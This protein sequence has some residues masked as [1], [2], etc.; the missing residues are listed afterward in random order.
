MEYVSRTE[1][2][3][4]MAQARESLKGFWGLAVGVVVVYYGIFFAIGFVPILGNI[5]SLILTGPF[6][7]GLTIFALAVSRNQDPQLSQL[8]NGFNKFGI[9]LGTYLLQTLFVML[10]SYC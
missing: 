3:E 1:N 10:W 8:F 6:I 4:L 9:A 7:L 2:K 5:A